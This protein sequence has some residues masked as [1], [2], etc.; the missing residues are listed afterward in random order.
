MRIG[1]L[2]LKNYR[3]FRDLRLQF[4]DGVIGILGL[5]GS[6]KSTI[7]EAIAWALFGNEEEIVRT[8]RDSIRFVGASSTDA[9]KAALEFELDDIEYRIERE[10]GGRSL[11][12]KVSLRSGGGVIA[13]GDK[14]VR[15]G[16]LRLLGM[17]YKAFFTSVFARQN[18][19]ADLQEMQPAKRKEMVLRMLRIDGL[20]AI[21]RAIRADK[22]GAMERIRGAETVLLDEDGADREAALAQ[23]LAQ[24]KDDRIDAERSLKDAQSGATA[25]ANKVEALRERMDALRK[26]YEAL[27]VASTELKANAR[28]LEDKK[29]SDSLLARRIAGFE[30]ALS[31]ITE[32][33]KAEG[34]WKKALEE[35]DLMEQHKMRFDKRSHLEKDIAAF[36]SEIEALG[37]KVSALEASKREEDEI[38]NRI[39]SSR[40]NKAESASE[41]EDIVGAIAAA[42]AKIAERRE[43][44]DSHTIKLAQVRDAGEKGACPTCERPLEDTYALLVDKLEAEAEI[45]RNQIANDEKAATAMQSDLSAID[46]RISALEKKVEHQEG[47][48]ADLLRKAAKREFLEDELMRTKEKRDQSAQ[49][50]TAMGEVR[51]SLEEHEASKK[52]FEN[53][54]KG[55]EEYLRLKEM[56]NQHELTKADR[57]ELRQAIE[58]LERE[59]QNLAELVSTLEPRK[60]LYESAVAEFNSSSDQLAAINTQVGNAKAQLGRAVAEMEATERELEAVRKSKKTID[61]LRKRADELGNLEEVFVSFKNDLIGRIAPTLGEITSEVLDLMTDG[62]YGSVS[63]DDDYQLRIEDGGAFH[64][65]DRYSGGEGDLAN[66]S[67]RLAISKVI[68]ERTGTNQVN[69]L[70]L[71]EV[72]GSLDPS[73]KR[74]VMMAL[75]GLS[76]QFRQIML[77]THVE[78]VKDLLANVINVEELPDGTS[79]AKVIS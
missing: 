47:R 66:L 54:N 56:Q 78:D 34:E 35:R 4:P 18:E 70:I 11:G 67:L 5:N 7:I 29:A 49:A 71:D 76:T 6:G 25:F 77:I 28:T 21:I 1:Y 79:T 58:Q 30:K 38:R 39:E 52:A 10:M 50:I 37:S 64:P 24:R 57:A 53:L 17:D 43:K 42:N 13:E 2:E 51:Y 41:R 68:A 27:N 55:H 45:A 26:D 74:S 44:L 12:M 23:R 75:S 19:L 61:Q 60:P 40:K 22:S 3:K 62:K 16:V 33:E 48:L 36:D 15:A 31:S 73:R 9:V 65:L 20:D 14:A 8:S 46:N 59:E 63:L 72:F 32:L 69:M